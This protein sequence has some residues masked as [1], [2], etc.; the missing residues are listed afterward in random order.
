MS[1]ISRTPIYNLNAV[2]KETGLSADVLRVWERR[3]ELPKPQR[4]PGGHRQYSDYDV[5]TIKWL[6]GRQ[7]EGFSISRAV[8]L[9]NE[10]IA[11]GEDPLSEYTDRFVPE[12]DPIASVNNRIE[13]LRTNWLSA[14]LDFDSGRADKT[15]N[16]AFGLFP[17]ETVC[18]EVM[19][20]GLHEIGSLWHQ[21]K[22]SVQQEHFATALVIRKIETLI[23]ATP[24]PTRDQTTL[25][26]CPAGEWHTFPIM[27]LT[28]MLRRKG[29]NVINLGANIPLDQM[30]QAAEAI[31]PNLIIMSAQQFSTAASLRATALFFHQLNVPLAFGGL[32]FNRIPELREK[33][34][35][36][37]LGEEL[38]QATEK[39]EEFLVSRPKITFQD[40]IDTDVHQLTAKAYRQKVISIEADAI[41]LLNKSGFS[42]EYLGE[43]NSF[44]SAEILA[45]LEFGN[46]SLIEEDFEWVIKM[47]DDR[48]IHPDILNKY[49]SA[50][51]KA[52]NLQLGQDGDLITD[53]LNTY[54][55][56]HP[57]Y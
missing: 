27:L 17:V 20:K 26:G 29:I 24:S 51:Q 1:L 30:G 45:A 5:A 31:Q 18:F 47:F 49:L 28:L 3:Y 2:L 56:E 10:L 21:G 34:P 16:Q 36:Y 37:F 40:V 52:I 41:N 44:F 50:F 12:I 25:L 7:E 57:A 23:S 6:R 8:K 32:I 11:S 13:I 55:T 54:I 22:A 35:G 33:I 9:W 38:S 14:C 48:N 4:S 42:A 46:L 43:V 53:W 15:L 19:Q 39:V